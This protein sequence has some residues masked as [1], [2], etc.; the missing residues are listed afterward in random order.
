VTGKHLGPEP[1]FLEIGHDFPARV[2]AAESAA[3]GEAALAALRALGLGW[4]PAHV[5]LRAGPA[6]ALV[7][8]VNPRLAGG[9]IPRMVEQATGID[10]V[11]HAVARAAGRATP[12]V[13]TRDLAASI[14]FLVAPHGGRLTGLRGVDEA[15]AVP[16]VVDVEPIR[17]PGTEVAIRHS[18]TD[19]LGYVI[20][21][22]PSGDA[23]AA[24]AELGLR[25]LHADMDATYVAVEVSR[26]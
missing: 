13:P 8:E 18:F 25:F 3:I 6:G 2:P 21:A 10:L 9:M 11:F 22:A 5:E 20:A 23:A 4:G 1:Y 26:T 15:R 7:I 17:P 24:A 19:R 16:H 12:P 14:R